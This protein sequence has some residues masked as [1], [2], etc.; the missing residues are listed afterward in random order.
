[1]QSGPKQHSYKASIPTTA[2][3]AAKT[4][5]FST[6]SWLMLEPEELEPLPDWPWLKP[7][8][9]PD[10]EEEPL[11]LPLPLPEE[12]VELAGAELAEPE[13][14]GLVPGLPPLKPGIDSGVLVAWLEPEVED[15]PPAFISR[16]VSANDLRT[17]GLSP[18]TTVLLVPATLL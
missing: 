4:L 10:P 18:S 9:L 11:P 1:M 5:P 8:P 14:L 12:D 13:A 6:R 17:V 15:D 2:T 3:M 16:P 7:V